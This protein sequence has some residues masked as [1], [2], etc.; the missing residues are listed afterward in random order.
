MG[1]RNQ[2]VEEQIVNSQK[3]LLI[4]INK[5][6]L[7]P[8]ENARAWQKHFRR[9]YPTILFKANKQQQSSNYSKGTALHKHSLLDQ[10]EL[11]ESMLKTTKAIG[12]ENLIQLLKNYARVDGTQ[13]KQQ[14]TV[15]VIGYPNVG[16]SSLINS[17]KKSRAAPVGNTPGIT[18]TMQEI[19]LDKN[20]V[21]LDSP[22]VV[23][24][25]KEQSDS[26]ILRS[27]ARVEDIKDPLGPVQA[28]INRV[29]K[30]ELLKT[31]KI[32]DFKKMEDF[33][34]NVARK[35]GFLQNKGIPNV[36]LTARTIIRDFMNGKIKYFSIPPS[37]DDMDEDGD[38]NMA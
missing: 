8:S 22:G 2:T 13:N 9:E 26:L 12:S 24:A 6:D 5:I 23:L 11:V 19:Q 18:K 17:L 14:I 3:K 1:S 16:K 4:V 21:L 25:A 38:L 35:K 27:A 31:Y 34:G 20:I 30:D 33:L 32:A 7:I 36:D 28:M 29:S 37:G 15:G 10:K